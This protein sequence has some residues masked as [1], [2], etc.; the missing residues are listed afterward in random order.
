MTNKD[1][2][3][4]DPNTSTADP[5]DSRKPYEWNSKYPDNAM[6]I[7]RFESVYVFVLFIISLLGCFLTWNRYLENLFL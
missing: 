2:D 7:I 3:A 1:Q 5:T 6:F 4:H